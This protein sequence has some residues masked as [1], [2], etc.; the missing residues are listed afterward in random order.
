MSAGGAAHPPR[1]ARPPWRDFMPLMRAFNADVL[2]GLTMV[3]RK[4]G[5][6]VG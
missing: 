3:H 4:Y 6:F 5:D 2:G 1:P